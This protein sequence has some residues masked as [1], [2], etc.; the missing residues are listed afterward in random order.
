MLPSIWFI[1]SK[2]SPMW[3]HLRV[4][5]TG[6]HLS[7]N[8]R[9]QRAAHFTR[10]S[11]GIPALQ[12]LSLALRYMAAPSLMDKYPPNARIPPNASV[13][14]LHRSECSAPSWDLQPQT[15]KC[16]CRSCLFVPSTFPSAGKMHLCH[17]LCQSCKY[18]YFCEMHQ[19]IISALMNP[20][21]TLPRWLN[22]KNVSYFI[23]V[24]VLTSGE[25][26]ALILTFN[27]KT[28]HKPFVGS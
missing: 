12:L 5:A 20:G 1:T 16:M 18:V 9:H 6:F 22:T 24:F 28:L 17:R 26:H 14:T 2:R 21:H 19:C 27:L 15:N 25:K 13:P 3:Q 23:S 10:P 7:W 11:A 4:Q 8:F